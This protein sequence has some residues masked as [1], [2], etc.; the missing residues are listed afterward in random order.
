MLFVCFGFISGF[1]KTGVSAGLYSQE[2]SSD[3]NTLLISWILNIFFKTQNTLST[4]K[5]FKILEA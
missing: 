5:L 1:Q 4:S 2:I 3:S